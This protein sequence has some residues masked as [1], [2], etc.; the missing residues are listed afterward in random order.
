MHSLSNDMVFLHVHVCKDTNAIRRKGEYSI[1][2]V[3]MARAL[4]TELKN[5]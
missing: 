4:L 1:M 2:D 5:F 3:F